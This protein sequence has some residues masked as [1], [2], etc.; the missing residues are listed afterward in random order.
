MAGYT[1]WEVCED[2]ADGDGITDVCDAFD[3]DADEWRDSGRRRWWATTVMPAPTS[4]TP[5]M[6]TVT[7]FPTTATPSPTTPV[8]GADTDGDG[9]GDNADICPDG[10]DT[11][12]SDGDGTP[13]DC[14]TTEACPADADGKRCRGRH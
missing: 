8:N 12:D 14:D 13:D 3:D 1:T 11:V 7:V 9:V 4:T 2:D 10:D 5:S 6:P